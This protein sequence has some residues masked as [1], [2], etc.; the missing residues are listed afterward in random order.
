MNQ[1]SREMYRDYIDDLSEW[2]F[3]YIFIP[4]HNL[5][6]IQL[7]RWNYFQRIMGHF[8]Y[9]YVRPIHITHMPIQ[10]LMLSYR[11]LIIKHTEVHNYCKYGMVLLVQVRNLVITFWCWY[12]RIKKENC[13]QYVLREEAWFN[14]DQIQN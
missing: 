4:R 12:I 11:P 3:I 9:N 5:S 7:F 14:R 1:Y 10:L 13:R 6:S 8:Y 2:A